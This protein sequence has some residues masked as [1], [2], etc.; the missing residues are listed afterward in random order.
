MAKSSP[1]SFGKELLRQDDWLNESEYKEYRMKLENSLN[2]AERNEKLV[3]RIVAT[4]FVVAFALMF[5]GGSRV[6]GS[7]DPWDDGATIISV[8]LG[9]VYC[10][11]AVVF[12]VGLASYFSRLRPQTRE[13]KDNI[14]DARLLELERQIQVLRTEI[15]E[16]INQQ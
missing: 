11:A 4:C 7:F 12:W 13:A 16:A 8:T 5:V 2:R 9:V 10:I 14:R 3:G 1:P 15:K 6:L